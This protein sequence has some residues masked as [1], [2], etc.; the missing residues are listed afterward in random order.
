[1]WQDKLKK[2]Y[3]PLHLLEGEWSMLVDDITGLLKE[4]RELLEEI[5]IYG[6]QTSSYKKDIEFTDAVNKVRDYLKNNAPE[7]K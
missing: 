2:K 6:L 7:P 5:S 1:M 4:Q 3:V